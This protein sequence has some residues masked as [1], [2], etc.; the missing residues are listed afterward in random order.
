MNLPLP[1]DLGSGHRAPIASHQHQQRARQTI[2][3]VESWSGAHVTLQVQRCILLNWMTMLTPPPLELGRLDREQCLAVG[4]EL[5]RPLVGV[6]SL[7]VRTKPTQLAVDG[8]VD[9]REREAAAWSQLPGDAISTP[10]AIMTSVFA[11]TPRP[12]TLLNASALAHELVALPP[13]RLDELAAHVGAHAFDLG[14]PDGG[15]REPGDG[16]DE[17]V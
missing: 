7:R 10:A 2:C 4:R 12:L 1:P 17:L 6:H 3:E 16:V 13:A 14:K 9:T 8:E 15:H 11:S 5:V